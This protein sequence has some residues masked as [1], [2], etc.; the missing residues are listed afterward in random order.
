VH[1]WN[2]SKRG[3]ICGGGSGTELMANHFNRSSFVLA[4]QEPHSCSAKSRT[5][6]ARRNKQ[7]I[8]RRPPSP[9]SP[10]CSFAKCKNAI[11]TH[12]TRREGAKAKA[13]LHHLSSCQSSHEES[14]PQR[15]Q[16]WRAIGPS[17]VTHAAEQLRTSSMHQRIND[18]GRRGARERTRHSVQRQGSHHS[19]SPASPTS[20]PPGPHP[21][22]GSLKPQ[23]P[24]NQGL[25]P[26]V[27]RKSRGEET[28]KGGRGQRREIMELCVSTTASAR[29]AAAPLRCVACPAA[30]VQLRRRLPA[31]GLS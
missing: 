6:N 16:V 14:G 7:R 8:V 2:A 30:A 23:N 11:H 19:T 24:T 28:P 12:R 21:P 26:Q 22:R 3:Q 17:H 27:H 20:S 13:P 25:P 5:R 31:R 15:P 4:L 10:F 18:T 29:A 1:C 9:F